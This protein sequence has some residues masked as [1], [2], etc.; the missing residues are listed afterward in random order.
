MQQLNQI[1]QRVETQNIYCNN[2]YDNN[3]R[4][5]KLEGAAVHQQQHTTDKMNE[6]TESS[7]T[8]IIHTISSE[9]RIVHKKKLN[10]EARN[11]KLS[12]TQHHQRTT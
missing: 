6:A 12:F 2:T 11:I 5:S 3:G 8:S 10:I 4:A 7:S 9:G 1:T